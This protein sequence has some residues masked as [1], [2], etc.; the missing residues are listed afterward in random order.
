MALKTLLPIVTVC[1]LLSSAARTGSKAARDEA[2]PRTHVL[3]AT[4]KTVSWGYYDASARP[5]LRI[6]SGEVVQVHTLITNSPAGLE[7]AF[8]PPREVEQALRDVFREVK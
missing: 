1:V 2:G 8:L 7:G 6:K 3:K 5:V 4:P